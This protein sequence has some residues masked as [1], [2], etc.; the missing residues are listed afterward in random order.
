MPLS[1]DNIV[2]RLSAK[3]KESAEYIIK[4][5]LAAGINNVNFIAALISVVNKEV[6]L[7]P[8]SEVLNYSKERLPEVWGVFSKTGQ[9]VAKGYGK[10]NYN[11]LAVKYAGKPEDLANFVYMPKPSGMRDPKNAG[12]NNQPG[13]GWKYRGRGFN[14]ITW[15]NLYQKLT[16]RF[17]TDYINKPDLINEPKHAARGMIYYFTELNTRFKPNEVASLEE[18]VKKVWRLNN[19]WNNGEP[20]SLSLGY[21]QMVAEA[22]QFKEYI[23]KV[24]QGGINTTKPDIKKYLFWGGL[25]IAGIF[26]Y[27]YLNKQSDVNKLPAETFTNF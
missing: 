20:T 13:D 3:Q 21:S 11:D 18:A 24:I 4:E 25:L 14:Q 7:I 15:R 17:K 1:P 27:K 16:D 9:K 26:V 8:K 5:C 23:E 10:Y 6:G 19:G 12:G 2:N 22:P